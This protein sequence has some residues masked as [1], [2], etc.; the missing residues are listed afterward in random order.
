MK[1]HAF[2]RCTCGIQLFSD[3]PYKVLNCSCGETINRLF[4]VHDIPSVQDLNICS[5]LE[6]KDYLVNQGYIEAIKH[7]YV[8][9]EFSHRPYVLGVGC[10]GTT[11][12]NIHFI[13]Q[14]VLYFLGFKDYKFYHD[15][16]Y[17]KEDNSFVMKDFAKCFDEV[18]TDKCVEE[19]SF[20]PFNATLDSLIQELEAINF[21]SLADVLENLF[22][23][24]EFNM[25]TRICDLL[26]VKLKISENA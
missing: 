23:D 24:N 17:P 5:S 19:L 20:I 11:D 25:D 22:Y 6:Y 7:P 4:L 8:D 2:Y 21:R 1:K 14:K 10:D 26:E 18:V 3:F 9:L 13:V 15:I 16:A 12:L